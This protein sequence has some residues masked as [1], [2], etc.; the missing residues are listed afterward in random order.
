MKFFSF[1]VL[2]VNSLECVSLKSQ[3]SKERPKIIDVSNN[4]PL[5]YLYSIKVSKCSGSCGN[6]NSPYAKLCL[7]DIVK[8]INVK[9][10]NLMSRVNLMSRLIDKLVDECT[11]V[12]DE[13]KIYNETMN[14]ISSDDC[15]S[16]T[17]YVVLFAGFLT[18]SIIIDSAFIC[19]YWYS[20]K[21]N[22]HLHS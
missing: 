22:D 7:P 19:F 21:D 8:N 1:N 13:N 3:E 5:F 11:N 4:E 15:T 6:I 12:I 16:C 2:S 9:V 10:F 14:T 17:L 18:T 20:K